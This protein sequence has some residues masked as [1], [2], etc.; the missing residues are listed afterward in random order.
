MLIFETRFISV[1]IQPSDIPEQIDCDI[2]DL[3]VGSDIY[4]RDI[5]IPGESELLTDPEILVLHIALPKVQV[6][7]EEAELGDDTHSTQEV[8]VISKGKEE[9]EEKASE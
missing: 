1:E 7:D 6:E 9:N 2:K 8:E 5:P 4:V 3:E